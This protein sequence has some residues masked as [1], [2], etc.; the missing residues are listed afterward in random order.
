MTNTCLGKQSCL[1]E[2]NNCQVIQCFILGDYF[3]V[4]LGQPIPQNS[5]FYV[6]IGIY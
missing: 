6:F 3:M 1:S 2:L 4:A 5:Y